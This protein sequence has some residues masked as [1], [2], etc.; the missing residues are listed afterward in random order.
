MILLKRPRLP[1]PVSA[2]SRGAH[3]RLPVGFVGAVALLGSS[4]AQQESA[5]GLGGLLE[6]SGLSS[7][8]ERLTDADSP[9]DETQQAAA[10]TLDEAEKLLRTAAERKARAEDYRDALTE[11]PARTE[12]LRREAEALQAS[13]P[14]KLP[15]EA[16]EASLEEL[17]RLAARAEA[18]LSAIREQRESIAAEIESVQ[19]IDPAQTRSMMTEAKTTLTEARRELAELEGITE[20]EP[21]QEAAMVLHRAR[22]QAA[23]AHL[24]LLE[25]ERLSREPRLA[26]LNAQLELLREREARSEAQFTALEEALARRRKELVTESK[27]TA[28]QAREAAEA[29]ADPEIRDLAEYVEELS[30]KLQAVT[31]NLDDVR[32][33]QREITENADEISEKFE[34]IRRFLGTG[35]A[36]RAFAQILLEERRNLP[37]TAEIRRRIAAQREQISEARAQ[38]YQL[39]QELERQ[40]Q[41]MAD[42]LEQRGDET[43]ARDLLNQWSSLSEQLRE[44]YRNLYLERL[45]LSSTAL[46]Y[47]AEVKELRDYLTS[48]LFWV[49]SSPPLGPALLKDLAESRQVILGSGKGR[50]IVE[51]IETVTRRSW[52]ALLLAALLTLALLALRPRLGAHLRRLGE[53]TRRPSRDH[54][55]KTGLALL[56]TLILA[57]P[58]PAFLAYVS[59]EF[60]EL[61]RG[62]AF[63]DAMAASLRW[64][65]SLLFA[66]FFLLQVSRPGGLGERHFRWDADG[67]R[68]LRFNLRWW[69][70]GYVPLLFLAMFLVLWGE[71]STV[72]S[73]ARLAFI[74]GL[75]WAT[76]FLARLLR[77]D[78]GVLAGYLAAHPDGWI[79]RLKNLW[80]PLALLAPAALIVL[81]G[82]GYF[83]TA[84]AIHHRLQLT[85]CLLAAGPIVYGLALR[86]FTI[87]ERRLALAER[88]RQREADHEAEE[89]E[90]ELP[91][92]SPVEPEEEE[93]DLRGVGDQTRHL[94]RF[95]V[96]VVVGI[97]IWFAWADL[98]PAVVAE[99][100]SA[101][102]GGLRMAEVLGALLALAITIVVVRDLP[103]ALEITV[104]RNLRMDAGSRVATKT[105][106]SYG[107]IAAG[108][109]AVFQILDVDWSRFGWI[110]AALVWASASG[111]RK[112]WRTSCA[113]SSCSS[114]GPSARATSSPWARSAASS[115]ASA[116]APPRSPTGTARNTLCRTR[117]SSPAPS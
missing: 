77:P 90:S 6:G 100:A 85:A 16:A 103:G 62:S 18:D 50:E 17:E 64:S 88:L 26:L 102:P 9:S 10:A 94:L 112:S 39:E 105:L 28:E 5:P 66:F 11:A 81:A 32:V 52:L 34:R 31:D 74:A 97:G 76:F 42:L 86:A 72:D 116:S 37:S 19:G 30:A 44:A 84:V 89:P 113:A 115:R 38:S 35:I 58:I 79:D 108:L 8:R 92:I 21:R 46:A 61:P 65:S 4:L 15:R 117:S 101:P 55:S 91:D 51:S 27:R 12:K 106:I 49:A 40:R 82:T 104:L 87:H 99:T 73:L 67:L 54:W 43:M 20:L 53:E 63:V 80:F 70:V 48:K 3:L 36:G 114:S 2:V 25:R 23:E 109:I 75:L 33:Q 111:S 13:E 69:A 14:E 96:F 1:K 110:A 78:T 56:L 24:E 47:M 107:L 68:S 45:D 95:L 98:A 71:T 59:W 29:D 41:S 57:L 60:S 93:L 22:I 7:A 83:L